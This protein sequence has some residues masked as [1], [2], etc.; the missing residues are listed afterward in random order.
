MKKEE[1]F[2]KRIENA[3]PFKEIREKGLPPDDLSYKYIPDDLL[4]IQDKDVI[5]LRELKIKNKQ[6]EV[7]YI[8]RIG[9]VKYPIDFGNTKGA[10]IVIGYTQQKEMKEHIDKT[11][12]Q[13]ILKYETRKYTEEES[14]I[15]KEIIKNM[16][17]IEEYDD[18]SLYYKEYDDKLKEANIPPDPVYEF[19]YVTDNPTYKFTPD[20]FEFREKETNRLLKYKNM[21]EL[22]KFSKEKAKQ[23]YEDGC[24]AYL[25]LF[26]EKHEFD[27]EDAKDCWVGGEVGGITYCGDYF[28]GMQ[29]IIED[30]DLDASEDAFF[31]WYDY[32]LRAAEFDLDVPNF[33][34]FIKG[35]PIT[36]EET[37]AKFESIKNELNKLIEQENE[38]I[39]QKI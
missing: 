22:E 1:S 33:K 24:N 34:S 29:T 2:K 17:P 7:V 10:Y 14:N 27:F 32:C 4:Y 28:V 30:I 9:T 3:V 25:Q 36:S 23:L 11:F 35:C 39:N 18:K 38:K 21:E 20:M 13:Y 37:F 19:N 31:K 16:K 5:K 26:C 6:K 15:A 12:Q 8:S